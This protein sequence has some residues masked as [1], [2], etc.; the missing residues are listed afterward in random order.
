MDYRLWQI[1]DSRFQIPV[2]LASK[3][4]AWLY[5]GLDTALFAFGIVCIFLGHSW[6]E[7][8]IALIVGA[9][10]GMST[11]VGQ[12]LA[13]Q[14]NVEQHQHDLLWRDA[15]TQKYAARL[16]EIEEQMRALA[17]ESE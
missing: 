15:L 10:F 13:F 12:V 17:D 9:M 11:F 7:L 5:V 16:A 4:F 14:Q 8:G 3:G 6:R 2:P 1:P